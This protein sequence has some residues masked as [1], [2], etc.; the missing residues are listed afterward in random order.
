M[1]ETAETRAVFIKS[2]IQLLKIHNFDGLDLCW[3]YPTQN[4]GAPQD[5]VSTAHSA[6]HPDNIF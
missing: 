2:A 5:R 3:T 4:G 6:N 1:A